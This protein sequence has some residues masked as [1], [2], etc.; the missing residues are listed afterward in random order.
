MSNWEET[1]IFLK[2]LRKGDGSFFQVF[3]SFPKGL[4]PPAF[5]IL[6]TADLFLADPYML[7]SG[8]NFSFFFN[9]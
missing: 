7:F 4:G 6:C 1:G 2:G 5:H 3:L 9:F 8:G